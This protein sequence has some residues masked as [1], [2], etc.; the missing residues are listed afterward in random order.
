VEALEA[1]G[2]TTGAEDLMWSEKHNAIN[3]SC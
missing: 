2:T 1:A 3:P